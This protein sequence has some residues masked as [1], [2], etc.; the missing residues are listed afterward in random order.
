MV[1]AAIA[2][3]RRHGAN[4]ARDED[5]VAGVGEDDVVGD[6]VGDAELLLADHEARDI[7]PPGDRERFAGVFKL[8]RKVHDDRIHLF[9]GYQAPFW[10]WLAPS[11]SWARQRATVEVR[12]L[13]FSSRCVNTCSA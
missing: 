2:R 4:H 10:D 7:D 9:H 12:L 3:T 8:A 13:R 11:L 6:A 5:A 1:Q